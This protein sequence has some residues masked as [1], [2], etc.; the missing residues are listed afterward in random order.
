MSFEELGL[1]QTVLKAVA[2]SGYTVPTEIQA[3]A[4]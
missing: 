2:D 3:E 4:I 1:S